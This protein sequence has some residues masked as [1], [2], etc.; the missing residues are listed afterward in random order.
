VKSDREAFLRIYPNL[1]INCYE[2][3]QPMSYESFVEASVC[4]ELARVFSHGGNLRPRV[5]A[6]L[7]A[8]RG[9][10]GVSAEV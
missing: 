2:R 5:E 4:H 8:E 10:V 9:L 1:R 6:V 7:T 3:S